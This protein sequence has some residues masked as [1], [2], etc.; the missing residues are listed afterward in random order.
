MPT[1]HLLVRVAIDLGVV[2]AVVFTAGASIGGY[3]WIKGG[4]DRAKRQSEAEEFA[5]EEKSVYLALDSFGDINLQPKNLTLAEL[6]Q[7]FGQPGSALIRP[8]SSTRLG[9]ACGKKWC[10]LSFVFPERGEIPPDAKPAAIM[11][12]RGSS[13]EVT[14]GG[15][16]V[17]EPVEEAKQ[18]CRS[19]GFGAE[20]G[21]HR[22][23]WDKDWSLAW[24]ET[25]G[26][27]DVL[28]FVNERVVQTVK[29]GG[30]IQSSATVG[31]EKGTSK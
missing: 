25:N 6:K 19:K 22:I 16:R 27:L 26:K 21:F 3:W 30:G 12:S 28:S 17:G 2:L 14:I 11:V 1:K 5:R 18:Y 4:P 29:A 13:H 9:W 10:A 20:T 31:G 15:V 24:A 7:R 23:A 8:D